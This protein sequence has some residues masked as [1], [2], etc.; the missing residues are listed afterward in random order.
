[1]VVVVVVVVMMLMLLLT[2]MVARDARASLTAR[3][4][5]CVCR[6]EVRESAG[7]DDGDGD[8]DVRDCDLDCDCAVFDDDDDDDDDG[9]CGEIGVTMV[10]C[11]SLGIWLPERHDCDCDSGFDSGF[12]SGFDGG[13]DELAPLCGHHRPSFDGRDVRV[14]RS[15]L[16]LSLTHLELVSVVGESN[17]VH[18]HPHHLVSGSSGH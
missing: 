15:P 17:G 18:H 12:G 16:L 9:G 4:F 8:D 14:K 6:Y 2:L 13:G 11:S 3:S 5:E 7:C 10:R 1:M